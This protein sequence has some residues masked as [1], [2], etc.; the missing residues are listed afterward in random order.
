MKIRIS[1]TISESIVDG[2]GIRFVVFTQGCPHHCAGCHNPD[3]HDFNGGKVIDT[4]EMIEEMK[5]YPY[6]LSLIHILMKFEQII[7][8][9]L[10]LGLEAVEIYASTSESNTIKVDEGNLESYNVKKLFG[11][12]IRGL[13][14]GKMGYVYTCLL[15]TS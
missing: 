8:R 6:M 14:N 9:G 15:Y 2:P 1:G 11:V 7:A 3:T 5:L 12:S 4:D 10:E 13:L